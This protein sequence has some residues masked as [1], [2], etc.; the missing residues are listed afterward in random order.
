MKK[1]VKILGTGCPKCIALFNLVNTV[2]T[3]N[4]INASI[5]KVEDIMEIMTYDVM[6]TPA[7]VID[8]K[9]LVKGRIPSKTEVLELLQDKINQ[10]EDSTDSCCCS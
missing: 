9:V 5:S 6:I 1:N 4:K 7:L 10:S 8:N 2:I 3:E